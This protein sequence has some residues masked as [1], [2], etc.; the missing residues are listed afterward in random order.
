[1]DLAQDLNNKDPNTLDQNTQDQNIDGV[2]H[3]V[4][5]LEWEIK[6]SGINEFQTE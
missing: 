3:Q 5:N 2:Q 6:I 1:M 4:H